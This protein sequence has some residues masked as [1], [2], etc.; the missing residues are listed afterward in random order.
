V[1]ALVV[2]IAAAAVFQFAPSN[3]NSKAADNTVDPDLRTADSAGTMWDGTAL[4]VDTSDSNSTIT[5][6]TIVPSIA[7]MATEK[8]ISGRNNDGMLD[9]NV[10]PPE[11]N[12]YNITATSDSGSN[13][14]PSSTVPV[15]DGDSATFYFSANAGYN[16]SV[17]TVD[18]KM[19]SQ[20]GIYLGH[21]TF[22]NVNADHTISVSSIGGMGGN[23]MLAINVVE[24]KGY[25]EYSINGGEFQRYSVPVFIPVNSDLTVIA[26][27]DDRC[28]FSGWGD[29]SGLHKA[30]DYTVYD[31][32]T[33]VS[34]DLHFTGA[35][36][37]GSHLML[38]L[39]IGTV[40]MLFLIGAL[41]WY[42]LYR[43]TYVLIEGGKKR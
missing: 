43:K 41:V 12:S 37:A 32:T 30:S 1:I 9:V 3:E 15:M 2:V 21:Y 19:L 27:A 7:K 17:V 13:I 29:A 18:G 36:N 42:D 20:T 25:A 23:V 33:S 22:T 11:A 8:V 40:V 24:G 6:N 14:T 39:A 34:L 26:V 16:V 4:T 5:G 31:L 28:V 10:T 38:E 35:N